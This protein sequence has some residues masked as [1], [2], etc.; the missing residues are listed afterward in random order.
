M[1]ESQE[2]VKRLLLNNMLAPGEL[3]K[4]ARAALKSFTGVMQKE[5]GLLIESR[6]NTA[7]DTL[8]S[9]KEVSSL[10]GSQCAGAC[11]WPP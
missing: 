7:Q 6:V 10:G 3:N 8:T 11:E 4:F 9:R 1:R 5:L 2:R